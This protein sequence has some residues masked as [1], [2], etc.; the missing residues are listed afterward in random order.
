MGLSSDMDVH[1]IPVLQPTSAVVSPLLGRLFQV[2]IVM[3]TL[4]LFQAPVLS[5]LDQSLEDELGSLRYY[6]LKGCLCDCQLWSGLCHL[7]P[8]QLNM[9]T[10]QWLHIFA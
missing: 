8:L 9:C 1:S 4:L 3:L 10:L 2:P 7:T 6:V 5:S